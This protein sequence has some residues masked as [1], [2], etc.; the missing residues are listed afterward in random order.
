MK[1]VRFLR[2]TYIGD[3]HLVA[4]ENVYMRLRVLRPEVVGNNKRDLINLLASFARIKHPGVLVPEAYDLRDV[5]RIYF[6]YLEGKPINLEDKVEKENFVFFLLNLLRELVHRGIMMPVISIEDFLKAEN[7]FMLPPCWVNSDCPPQGRYVFVAPEFLKGQR[8]SVASTVYVFGKLID[9]LSEAQE[10]K[11]FV[12]SFIKEEPNKRKTHFPAAAYLLSEAAPT[13]N[14]MGL[15]LT[16]IHRGEENQILNTIRNN[17]G[18]LKTIFVYGPQRIGKTTLL[19]SMS[20]QLRNEGYPVIWATDLQSFI[21]GILQFVDDRILSNLDEQDKEWVEKVALF[22]HVNASEVTLRIAKILNNLSPVV[23]IIDDAHEMD[24]SLKATIEQLQ[25]YNYS[26]GHTLILA[27]SQKNIP[28]PYDLIVELEPFDLPK[29]TEMISA[30]FM[31]NESEVEEFSKW[32]HIISHGLPGQVVELI[33]IMLKNNALRIEKNRVIID[34]GI[35]NRTDFRQILQ[36]S[37][38]KSIDS[39]AHLIAILG[40]RFGMQ[41]LEHLSLVSSQDISKINSKLT[42]LIDNGLVYWED[43]KYRFIVSDAWKL[44]YEQIETQEKIRLH[45]KLASEVQDAAKKA[46]HL[47]M[48]GKKTSAIAL[49]LLVA[50]KELASYHDVSVAMSLLEEAEKLLE[51]RESYALNSL[52]FKAL[53]IKQDS[54]ALERY[55]LALSRKYDFLRYSALVY[56][57]KINLAKQ[58]EEEENLFE[59]KTNYSRLS[60]LCCKMRR[61]MFSGEKLPEKLLNEVEIL[62]AKLKDTK[63]HKKLKSLTLLLIAQNVQRSSISNLEVLN[64]ARQIAQSEGFLDI[65]ASI[66]NELGTRLAANTEASRLFEHVVEIAHKIGSDGLAMTALSNMIWTSLYRGNIYRMFQDLTR[67]RQLTSITGNIQLEAY[68]YFIEANFHMYNRELDEALEDYNRE[69]SIEKYLGIEE[70]ALRGIV[71]AYALSENIKQARQVIS[72]NIESPAINNQ[73]FVYFRDLF[74]AEDDTE[75]LKAWQKF[76]RRDTP[77]WSEETCQIFAERLI[78]LDKDGFLKFAKQLEVNAIKSGAFLSLA[79]IYEGTAIAYKSVGA[80]P[81][82]MNY[83]EKAISIYRTRSFTNAATWLEK[84]MNLS[85]EA[86]VFKP[87]DELRLKLDESSQ[88]PL[89]SIEEQMEKTMKNTVFIQ[90]VLDILKVTDPQDEI[91]TTMEFLVSKIMNLLPV[92]SAGLALLDSRGK[93]LEYAGFNIKQVPRET[94]VSYTPFELCSEI[95]IYD[96]FSVVLYVA[97]Q[98]LHLDELS[99]YELTKMILNLQEVIIYALKNIIIYHRSITDPLTG[100]HTRWYFVTRLHEEFERVRRYGGHFSVVMCDI[101]DFK[102]IN[103]TLGHRIGDE[104]LKFIASVLRSSTRASD[105][106]GRYGGEEFILILPNTTQENAAKVA[107]KILYQIIETNPFDFRVTMSFG[108]SGYPEQT[109]IEPEDLIA[110]ADKATYVSKERGKACVTIFH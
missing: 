65:L 13:T 50:R 41:E 21:I 20:D 40:E 46:W 33:K 102:K 103:D 72:E 88:K 92:S 99:G 38:E 25:N 26:F 54:N 47:K 31:M 56:S 87:F 64:Q 77:Y 51:G 71:C 101:D 42:Q 104:V 95:E 16:T 89:K 109:V 44:L 24:L 23:I 4:D 79:Q 80:I 96:G 90:H 81:L 58:M 19:G 67:L 108:V 78:K 43:G 69:L 93:V 34:Q 28:L 11:Q 14:L 75:F 2:E 94:K 61:I 66:L 36:L 53:Q 74:L 18:R 59:S 8:S 49:Y 70:R 68:S 63:L 76:L 30:M 32:I 60:K 10:V 35:I 105:I 110:L 91:Y 84:K 73:S 3:E 7:F 6:P 57:S 62:L 17:E 85:S 12:S 1:L 100:L 15:R 107:E 97:N 39:G 48:L 106:V 5:P 52:K 82:A 45:S 27:S 22:N 98:A 29:T 83:A 9:S 37:L 55:A 86:N